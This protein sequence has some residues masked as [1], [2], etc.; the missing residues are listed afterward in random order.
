MSRSR[1]KSASIWN[2]AVHFAQLAVRDVELRG[3]R[4]RG[5]EAGVVTI[6][7]EGATGA[8]F[9]LTLTYS[10]A[11]PPALWSSRTAITYGTTPCQR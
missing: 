1:T 10:K 2:R 9:F 8:R 11:I 6:G 7:L 3:G 4:A 5:V